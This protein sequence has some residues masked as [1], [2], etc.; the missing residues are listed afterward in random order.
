MDASGL[1]SALFFFK[2]TREWRTLPSL[3]TKRY[4][5][6]CFKITK[7][8]Q[9]QIMVVGGYNSGKVTTVVEIYDLG[10][11][12]ATWEAPSGR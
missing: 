6:E 1:I 7:N 8:R 10:A 11:K 2:K 9:T 3:S 4:G 5:H 12:P